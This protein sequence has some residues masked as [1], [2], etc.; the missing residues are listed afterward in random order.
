LHPTL[1]SQ[2]DGCDARIPDGAFDQASLEAALPLL[3]VC[4]EQEHN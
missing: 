3:K 4:Y 2:Y 1:Y